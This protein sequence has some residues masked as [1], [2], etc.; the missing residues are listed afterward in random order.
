MEAYTGQIILFAGN[1]EPEGWAFCDG[2]QLQ[3]NSYQALYALIGTT[4]G[5][6]ARTTFN[7]PDLRGRLA[8][9]Q[10][11][12]VARAPAPQLTARVL[13]QR[14]GTETVA[15]QV[16]EMPAHRHTLQ[17]LNTPA[18]A[19]TPAGQLPAIGQN[20]D[21]PYFTPPSGST[22]AVNTLAVNAVNPS[23]A[24]QPHDNRMATQTLNYL[25]CLN[26]LF[27]DRP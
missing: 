8:I 22:P 24:G 25:I 12:G 15:L 1:Y 17:A 11:Q 20:G 2:R 3:I 16:A 9:G 18:T 23:G 26:G 10:G 19:L 21:A 27:P 5:G 4:Y 6:D 13:G 7:L 14:L